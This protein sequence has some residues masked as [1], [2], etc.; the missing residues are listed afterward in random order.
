MTPRALGALGM[1]VHTLLH[2]S[3]P[4]KRACTSIGYTRVGM[5]DGQIFEDHFKFKLYFSN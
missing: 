1:T 4:N 3:V 5:Q 2:S